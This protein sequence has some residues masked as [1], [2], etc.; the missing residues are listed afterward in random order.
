MCLQ[1][2]VIC[3]MGKKL[4]TFQVLSYTKQLIK[5]IKPNKPTKGDPPKSGTFWNQQL[6]L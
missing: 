1:K 6:M 4:S 5:L 3:F 2:I